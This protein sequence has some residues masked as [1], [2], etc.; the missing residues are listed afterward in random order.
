MTR[1]AWED[2]DLDD[3]FKVNWVRLYVTK[4]DD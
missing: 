4:K 3:D 1:E 2:E